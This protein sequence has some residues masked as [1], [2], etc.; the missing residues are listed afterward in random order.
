MLVNNH[1]RACQDGEA[2]APERNSGDFGRAGPRHKSPRQ[3][4]LCGSLIP[5]SWP[6]VCFQTFIKSE[7]KRFN[8]FVVWKFYEG[9]LNGV[10]SGGQLNCGKKATCVTSEGHYRR[11]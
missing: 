4:Y 11:L 6:I 1:L 8:C 3:C 9:R 7:N 2:S 5:V 10:Y